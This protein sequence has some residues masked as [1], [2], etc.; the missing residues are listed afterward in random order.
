M[1]A[2]VRFQSALAVCSW[3]EWTRVTLS[4]ASSTHSF[5]FGSLHTF[6]LKFQY[7]HQALLVCIPRAQKDVPED[8]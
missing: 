5:K 3:I 4:I 7:A 8:F 1:L 6:A 2:S